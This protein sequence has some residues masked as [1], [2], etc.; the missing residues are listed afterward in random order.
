M[1]IYGSNSSTPLTGNV[2]TRRAASGAFSLEAEEQPRAATPTTAPRVI[3][4]IDALIALQGV[5]HSSERR[6]RAVRRGRSVLDALDAL[7]LALLSGTLDTAALAT[8]KAT[9]ASLSEGTGE[10]GLDTV[11]AEISLRAEV[12]LAKIGM[13]QTGKRPK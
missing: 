12:E 10:P 1:R 4:G 9:T 3:G 5:E 2:P 13:P 7:K 11:L 8:L 6:R